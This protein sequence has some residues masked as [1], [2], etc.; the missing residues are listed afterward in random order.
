[1]PGV[2][3]QR[4]FLFVL[5]PQHPFCVQLARV[6]CFSPTLTLWLHSMS[7]GITARIILCCCSFEIMPGILH[8]QK[9]TY[10]SANRKRDPMH[11][12]EPF[13]SL[14]APLLELAL[15]PSIGGLISL[16]RGSWACLFFTSFCNIHPLPHL[17]PFLAVLCEPNWGRTGSA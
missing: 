13:Y 2:C 7:R 8:A 12:M 14:L 9:N 3:W 11:G 4:P 5:P 17:S 10:I 6:L 15:A 1:M 16:P